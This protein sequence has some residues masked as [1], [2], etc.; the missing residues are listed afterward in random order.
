MALLSEEE[1]CDQPTLSSAIPVAPQ[2]LFSWGE[3]MSGRSKP[4]PLNYGIFA[5]IISAVFIGVIVFGK[6]AVPFAGLPI[7]IAVAVLHWPDGRKPLKRCRPTL[8]GLLSFAIV[9]LGIV[10]HG[11]VAVSVRRG[12]AD[13]SPY[14][15]ENDIFLISVWLIIL[16]VPLKRMLKPDEAGTTREL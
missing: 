2:S 3:S 15:L 11:A 13:L 16:L 1:R 10:A 14:F 9:I 4:K 7:C 5:A 8:C 6:A 12:G